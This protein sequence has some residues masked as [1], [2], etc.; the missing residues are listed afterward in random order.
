MRLELDE[1]RHYKTAISDSIHIKVILLGRRNTL[2]CYE[3]VLGA[4][5]VK[6]GKS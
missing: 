3:K 1:A 2:G 4:R 5:G 6:A